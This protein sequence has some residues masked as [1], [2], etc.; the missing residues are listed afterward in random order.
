[1]GHCSQ[2][3]HFLR[4]YLFHISVQ[5]LV[6]WKNPVVSGTVFFVLF[7]VVLALRIY[8]ALSVV[9]YAGLLLLSTALVC[10]GYSLIFA[11]LH[12]NAPSNPF[13]PYLEK[14]IEL[15]AEDTHK[16]IESILNSI[17]KRLDE[18]KAL[19]F[20]ESVVDSLKFGVLLWALTYIGQFFSDSGLAIFL[21]VYVFTV[22]KILDLYHGPITK[23]KNIM[24]DKLEKI[25]ELINKKLPFLAQKGVPTKD[26]KKLD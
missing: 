15:T 13:G 12:G 2:M 1:M 8:S 10:R 17:Q 20:I 9:G 24:M 16:Q 5:D 25:R 4:S 3:A 22:P 23:Y 21:L 6:L 19:F 14:K 18:L 7:F 26:E 11:K